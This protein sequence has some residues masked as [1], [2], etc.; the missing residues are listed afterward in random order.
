MDLYKVSNL[1]ALHPEHKVQPS[2]MLE[3]EYLAVAAS[4]TYLAIPI[5]H[6]IQ[7]C[8]TTQGLLYVLNTALYPVEKIEWFIYAPFIKS[9]NLI[10]TYCLAC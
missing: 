7:I 2:H 10:K 6:E 5:S 1:P 4:V 8:L 3:G 9:P